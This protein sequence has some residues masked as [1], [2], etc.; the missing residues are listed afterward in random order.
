MLL[1]TAVATLLYLVYTVPQVETDM[2]WGRLYAL[3]RLVVFLGVVLFLI[4]GNVLYQFTRIGHLSRLLHHSPALHDEVQAAFD[5]AET[6]PL[7][8]LIP[9]Y[10]EDAEVVRKTLIS[11]AVQRYPNK[12]VVLLIDDPPVPDSADDQ[13][14]LAAARALPLEISNWLRYP[15][16]LTEVALRGFLGR[17]EWGS[18]DLCLEGKM[19]K[20]VRH[21]VARWFDTQAQ[22]YP[23]VDHADRF[24]TEHVLHASRDS[25]L[26]ERRDPTSVED[27]LSAYQQ[28]ADAFRVEVTCFERKRYANL[29]H[30]PSKAANLNSY[31]G[32]MGWHTREMEHEGT[33]LIERADAGEATCSF[34]DAA[35]I[36]TLDA[37]SLI[38]PDY[39]PRL[40]HY[41]EQPKQRRVG[42]V[43]T[44]Y[45]AF[46]G[47]P[48]LL[49]RV[50]GATTDV[51][52]FIHQGFT[53]YQASFWVGANAVLRK[54]ALN[55]IRTLDFERGYPVMKYIQDRTVIEDTES[56]VDLVAN[57]WSLVN[58]PERL[59]YSATPPDFGS[60][61]IQRRRWANGGL[62]ILPKLLRYLWTGIGKPAKAAE[63]LV[64]FHYLSSM[65]GVSAGL[66]LLLCFP[67]G[68]QVLNWWLPLTA[69]PYFFLYERDLVQAGYRPSDLPRVYALNLL[70]VPVQLAGVTKSL[71]QAVTGQKTP[72]KRTPKVTGRT[73]APAWYILAQYAAI[74]FCVWGGLWNALTGN[75]A[76]TLFSGM[77][78]AFLLYAMLWFVGWHAAK[79][80]VVL[81]FNAHLRPRLIRYR[82]Q[83]SLAARRRRT[84]RTRSTYPRA[85]KR[86]PYVPVPVEERS[87]GE[88][89]AVRR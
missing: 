74:A 84:H 72:F 3:C 23:A 32:L 5:G 9:S 70:L 78:V 36:I 54:K 82:R 80:D 75:L 42:V 14:A 63:G 62:I 58:Y 22:Q 27:A 17:R 61:I 38:S 65:A 85:A 10:K 26:A 52:Y 8:I 49:E 73:A 64:R 21:G 68:K 69:L 81:S 48:G 15:A 79:E 16:T 39:A 57:G 1:L 25:Y 50:A 77:N 41:L 47:A 6:P 88:E 2:S 43:Q 30:D 12:R 19:L 71:H 34:P 89:W 18:V 76:Q 56:T 29:S 51:Q 4:Y 67:F 40:I 35:F 7:A 60:L 86:R 83:F 55:D 24:F 31:L 37:D 66:V 13:R 59:A 11:A 46:P 53:H 45:S 20:R 28:L 87:G 33:L 44:P